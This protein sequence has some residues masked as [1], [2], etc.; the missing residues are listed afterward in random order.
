MHCAE[1]INLSCSSLGGEPWEPSHPGVLAG[2]RVLQGG[3][4]EGF[5]LVPLG[6]FHRT[7]WKDVSRACGNIAPSTTSC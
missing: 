6:L 4:A 7:S 3:V 1:N 5:S 2:L